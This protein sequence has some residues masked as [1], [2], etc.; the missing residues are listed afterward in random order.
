MILFGERSLA[1]V[2]K[3]YIAHH[4]NERNHQGLDNVFPFPDERL[5]AAIQDGAIV[6]SERLGCSTFIITR[7]R[8]LGVG[9]CSPSSITLPPRRLA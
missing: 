6:K 5:T 4:Q 9:I 1:C 7:Q 8:E 3:N 2:L